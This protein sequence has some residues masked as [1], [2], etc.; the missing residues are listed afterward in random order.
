MNKA[1]CVDLLAIVFLNKHDKTNISIE[2]T[3]CYKILYRTVYVG[4]KG[5]YVERKKNAFK[6]P[7][8]TTCLKLS[9]KLPGFTAYTQALFVICV[10]H[11]IG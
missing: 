8:P 11:L 10:F 4:H 6:C 3:K 9:N 2:N 5:K 7:C 1:E